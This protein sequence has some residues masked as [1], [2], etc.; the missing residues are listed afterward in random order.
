MLRIIR[1]N[2]AKYSNCIRTEFDR[3]RNV[4]YLEKQFRIS[5]SEF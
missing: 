3:L 1:R 4:S 5:H 2:K